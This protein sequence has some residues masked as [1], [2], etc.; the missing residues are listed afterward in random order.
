VCSLGDGESEARLRIASRSCA[1]V[2]SG[3]W[4]YFGF[5]LS[6]TPHSYP[7]AS[8]IYKDKWREVVREGIERVAEGYE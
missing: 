6:S 1:E 8:S 4:G 7:H 5:T 3:M 2:W